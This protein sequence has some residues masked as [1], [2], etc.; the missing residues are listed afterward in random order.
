MGERHKAEEKTTLKHLSHPSVLETAQEISAKMQHDF[1]AI[2]FLVN[3]L[4]TAKT[5]RTWGLKSGGLLR[6][7]EKEDEFWNW[8][9]P[10]ASSRY[11]VGLLI[12][13]PLIRLLII[14]RLIE[15]PRSLAIGNLNLFFG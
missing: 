11:A 14:C 3:P 5:I 9:G 10:E 7:Y 8:T 2:P 1:R 12:N 4:A 6:T 13:N 15:I